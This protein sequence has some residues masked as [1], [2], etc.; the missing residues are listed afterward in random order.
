MAITFLHN[1]SKIQIFK[2]F[3]GDLTE[4]IP[5]HSHPK[6]GYEIHL[7]DYGKGILDT[8]DK[9][10]SLTKNTLFITG[11]N[12]PHKQ[13]PDK[14]TPMHE[15][16]VYFKLSN[17]KKNSSLISSFAS[18]DFWIGKSTAEIRRLFRQMIDENENGGLW[19]ED[20]LSALSIKLIGEISRLYFPDNS[21]ATQN[22][23][24]TDLNENRSWILDELLR[25]DCSNVTLDDFAKK[26]GVCPRQAERIIK[27]YYGASFKKLRYD[28]K[29]AM[30][31]TL[32]DQK[33]ISVEECSARCGYTSSSA[34]I[35]AFKQKYKIT[36]KA[37]MEQIK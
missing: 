12:V 22:A 28:A 33:N 18:C 25:E 5:M 29:M 3:S 24:S 21:K 20:I 8:G 10:Y 16:C 23:A 2:I 15:L 31:A 27:E 14:D 4:I 37:Y 11:P 35:T 1:E 26:M 9:K 13:T 19:K 7:I 32:L 34:F 36:P 17:S 6:N 30:A